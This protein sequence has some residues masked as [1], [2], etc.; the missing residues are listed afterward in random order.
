VL[1]AEVTSYFRVNT[2]D[3]TQ[4]LNWQSS[5]VVAAELASHDGMQ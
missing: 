3:H 1:H 2:W 5:S 4:Q